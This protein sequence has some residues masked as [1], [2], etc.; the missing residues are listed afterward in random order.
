MSRSL[1][2]ALDASRITIARLTGTEH[3]ALALIRHLIDLNDTRPVPH[4]LTLYF[5]D[6]PEPTLLPISGHVTQRVIPFRRAWTHLRFASALMLDRPDVTFVPAHTLPLIFPGRAVVTVHDLGYRYFP[7]AHPPVSRHYLEMT[8]RYSANRATIVLAD[9]QATARDLTRF[10][11][12]DPDKIRVVYPGVDPPPVTGS[13][14]DIRQK[15]RLPEQYFLFIGTLQPR[16]NIA[17]IVQAFDRW[18]KTQSNPAIGLVLAG[19]QGWL[20]DPA[21]VEGVNNVYLPGYIDDADKGTLMAGA[22]ALVFPT[23]YEGFGFPVIEAMH[24]GTPVIG[25]NT[26]SLPELI[27]D[28]GLTVDPTRVSA[29][30]DALARLAT[31]DAHIQRLRTAG[32]EQAKRFTWSQAAQQALTALENAAQ[33]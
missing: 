26:S 16:K 22:R 8:T 19:G 13:P 7:E 4:H 31:D 18:Q 12:T 9:S 30:A 10:Y 3:Y 1:H 28:A 20:F 23:L 27:G 17:R 32:Y 33:D 25:S 11:G 24:C 6:T 2:I 5:R 14:D 15:Y 21:W 29:I